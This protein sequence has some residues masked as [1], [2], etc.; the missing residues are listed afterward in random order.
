MGN[1]GSGEDPGLIR[2]LLDRLG[3]GS[4]P[5]HLNE[6]LLSLQEPFWELLCRFYFRLEID[7]WR[8]IPPGP[9]LVVGVHSGAALTMD[10][11][12]LLYA[13]WRHFGPDRFLHGTA[14]DVLMAT[15]GLGDYFREMGV[16]EA[17]PDAVGQALDSGYDVVV[18]PGGEKDSMRHWR[19]RDTAVLGGRTGFVRMA[20]EHQVP[21]VPVATVGG[22]DTVFIVSEG[23][24]I[25]RLGG[26]GERLRARKAPVIVGP[27]FGLMIESIPMHIPLPAKIRTE[28]LDPIELDHDPGRM[29]D[30]DYLREVYEEVEGSIQAGMDRLAAKR[31]FPVFF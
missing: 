30:D 29:E 26:L 13:W 27:P 5:G 31:R 10:A 21:I 20:L 15:P 1:N 18:W 11:W 6:T 17:S 8:R 3:G 25:T 4:E 16:L 24:W 2:S 19:K 14:H 12:T 9:C 7:G 28:F 23:E 22:H